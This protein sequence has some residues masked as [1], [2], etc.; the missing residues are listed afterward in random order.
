VLPTEATR[1]VRISTPPDLTDERMIPPQSLLLHVNTILQPLVVEATEL[2]GVMF[3][4]APL[5]RASLIM[6]LPSYWYL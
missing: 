2:E 4:A 5:S 1:G 6:G 3:L